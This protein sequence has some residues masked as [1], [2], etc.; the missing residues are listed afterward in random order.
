[1]TDTLSS[2]HYEVFILCGKNV[3]MPRGIPETITKD[4]ILRKYGAILE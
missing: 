2:Q 1:M 3:L 4:D